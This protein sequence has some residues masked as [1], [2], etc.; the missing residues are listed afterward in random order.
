MSTLRR[1]RD[2]ALGVFSLAPGLFGIPAIVLTGELLIV[3][4]LVAIIA[5][6]LAMGSRTPAVKALSAPGFVLGIVT[7]CT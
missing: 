7:L 3:S 1:R 6:L 4:G 2:L 5:G